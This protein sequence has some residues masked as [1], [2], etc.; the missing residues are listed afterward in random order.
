MIKKI[1]LSIAFVIGFLQISFATHVVGGSLTY[2]YMGGSTYVVTLKL[3]RDC[4]PGTAAL[5]GSVTIQVRGNNGAT[6]NPSKNFTMPLVSASYVPS[7]LDPCAVPP[8][9]MPCVQEGIYTATVTNLP[10]NLGGYHL[11]YQVCCRNGSVQNITNPLN[12]GSSFYTHIPNNTQPVNNNSSAVFNLFPPLFICVNQPFTFNHAAT[13]PDGDSLVYGL[14]QPYSDATAPTFPGNIANFSTVNWAGGYNTANPLG[15]TPF[16]INPTTGLLTGT[17]GTLGQFVVGV[18]VKEYRNGVLISQ[19][20]RDFQFNVLNCPQPPPSLAIPNYTINNGCSASMLAQGVSSVSVTWNSISPGTPGQYNSF[21][22]CTS[23]CLSNT[24]TSSGTPPAF[25]DYV[26]CGVSTSCAGGVVCDTF[27]VTFNPTLSVSIAPLNPTLCFGQTAI[28]LTAT[29]TGGTP[30]YNYLWDNVTTTQTLSAGPGLHTIRV[31]D[32]TGCPPAFNSITVTSFTSAITANAGAD[33]TVCIQSPNTTITGT[34]TGATGGIWS[35]GQGS[36]SPTNTTLV[37]MTYIPSAGEL[38]AG[39]ADLILTTTGNGGCPGDADTVR[40]IYRNFLGVITTTNTNISCFGLTN[41]TGSV[42]IAG[43]TAPYSYIWTAMPTQTTSAVSG[44]GVGTYSVKI[45]DAIGCVSSA[46]LAITQPLPL[47]SSLTYTNVTCNGA[48]NGAISVSASGGT[49]PYSYS[50]GTTPG[51]G[52]TVNN[53]AA[54]NYTSTVTD[55][56]GC[57]IT[58]TVVITQPTLVSITLSVTNVSCFNG[59][60]GSIQSS[61]N[62]GTPPYIYAWSPNI[63]NAPTVT[64]LIAGTYSLNILDANNCL[65]SSSTVVT[66]PAQLQVTATFTNE[67]CSYSN[68]GAAT[69][70]P[71]G[72]T[73]PYTYNWQPGNLTTASVASLSAGPYNLTVTD[74]NGCQTNTVVTITEPI[75]LTVSLVS[76]NNISCFGGNN[77]AITVNAAG[78]TPGYAYSWQPNVSSTNSA[79]GLTAGAYTITVTDFRNC[80]SKLTQVLTQPVA[81][82]T[83]AANS[84][85]VSCAGGSNGAITSNASGGTAPYNFIWNPIG[86]NAQNVTNIGAGVYSILVTDFNGCIASATTTVNQPSSMSLVFSVSNSSCTLSNGQASVTVSGGLPSYSYVW[87]PIGGTSQVA[88]NLPAG[89]Y[90][91]N[92]TDANGCITTGAV[93]VNDNSGPNASMLSTTNVSCFGGTNGSATVGVSGGIGPFTYSWQPFGGT[94][95]TANGLSA[96]TYVVT[97]TDQS[98]G[99]QSLATTSPA[100]TEPTDIF[101]TSSQTNVSCFGGSNGTASAIVSGGTGAYTYSW[102]PSGSTS[103]N[104]AGLAAGTH[105]VRV[106][107]G[108][109]CIKTQTVSITQPAVL[110]VVITTLTNVSCFGGANGSAAST[111]SGGTFPYTYNWS[112]GS[113][114]SNAVGLSSGPLSLTVTDSKGCTAVT[115]TSIAQPASA[116]TVAMSS[117]AVSCFGGNNGVVSA[118]PSGGTAGYTYNWS[119]NPGNTPTLSGVNAGVK[120]VTVTDAN[121][122]SANGFVTVNQP[123]AISS[124]IASTNPTCG[125]SNGFLSVLVSGG[126]SPYTYTWSPTNTNGVSIGNQPPGN[127]SV[128]INDSKG[129]SATQTATLTNVPG[130]SLA[131]VSFSGTS[132]F[133]GNNGIAIVNAT[134]GVGSYAY[135]WQPYGGN[136]NVGSNLV[137][138]NYTCTVFDGNGCSATRTV[139][140]SQPAQLNVTVNNATPPTCNSSINGSMSVGVSGGTPGYFYSWMPV[141]G[142]GSTASNLG[143]GIYTVSVADSKGCVKAITAQLTAPTPLTA[144]IISQT[145]PTCF[146]VG[147]GTI[148]SSVFGGTPPYQFNWQTSPVQTAPQAVNLTQGTYSLIITDNNNCAV[149]LTANLTAPSQVITGAA[150][151]ATICAGQSATLSTSA[152]GGSGNYFYYWTPSTGGNTSSQVV[153]P[154]VNTNYTVTAYDQYG[155][156]GIQSIAHVEVYNL[157][158]SNVN[159][160]GDSPICPGQASIIYATTNGNTGPLSFNWNQG[161]GSGVGPFITTPMMPATYIVTVTSTFCGNSVVD[162]FHVSFNPPPTVIINPASPSGCAPG[163]MQFFDNSISGNPNDMLSYWTWNFGDGTTSNLQ[164]PVHS[165]TASGTYTV[166]L[167]VT[168]DAGCTN[169]NAAAPLTVTMHPIPNAAF[170]TNATTYNIPFETT[171]FSNQ[172]TPAGQISYNWNFGDGTSSSLQN[173]THLYS[174]L[175]TFNIQLVVTNQFGCKDTAFAKIETVTDIQVPTAFTPNENGPSGGIYDI[176]SLTNDIFFPYSSGV[177]TYTMSIF[178]R[179][180]ELIFETSDFKQGWDGYYRGKLSPEGVYVWK[181]NLVWENGKSFNKV[182]DV[183]LLR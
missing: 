83:V 9:P 168:T 38:A 176:T 14:Y 151:G 34:V 46:T 124:T 41:G 96:G 125:N 131:V 5:P 130:P 35:G 94:A 173:P 40:I 123:A 175:G 19:T 64:G 128:L 157:N 178:N 156:A 142:T 150:S 68:D 26:V 90:S 61:V 39:F 155:C 109:G 29:A 2:V 49:T 44:L 177:K 126:S 170:T 36:F 13:D 97:V 58:N 108:N 77:G 105:T 110:S 21:L 71:S 18:V 59:A 127:Y 183:T 144:N 98:T 143:A 119:P 137:A 23:G 4:G 16:T 24:V 103:S 75:P 167:Q 66:Q 84:T 53:L 102:S 10:A 73:G 32:G 99:C 79:S 101:I 92:V 57:S 88:S 95:A 17:P 114:A 122:C 69:A 117:T 30:P 135:N 159:A 11:Y 3:Y 67:T 145:N 161:L 153:A 65:V 31:N 63:G 25:V 169:N 180:G 7:S 111:V 136:T 166:S 118:T 162:S 91:V 8:N 164:N 141:G 20:I 172:S 129:C 45:T 152:S 116:L 37:N 165:Y 149:T 78:G 42:S 6:F 33:R 89:A 132:C 120:L 22:A 140:I 54:G 106:T 104:A 70:V 87:S 48:T 146:N 47:N 107:D 80:I 28:T 163:S 158:S 43:G 179:W 147:N 81:A 74:N 138:G 55:F 182:G 1:L 15:P 113:L 51:T 85:S 82:L 56:N 148:S 62:G 72:G 181:I 121:G 115:N 100:I 76:S 134:G 160:V 174:G 60:N 171:V 52:S 93:T 133:G 86:I 50:W 27:R 112:S 154:T 139:A 12:T